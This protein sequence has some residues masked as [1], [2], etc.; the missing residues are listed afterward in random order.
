[1]IGHYDYAMGTLCFFKEGRD[2]SGETD[3]C[4]YEMPAR[5]YD[6]HSKSSKVLRMSRIFVEE[7]VANNVQ[8]V[9]HGLKTDL[10]QLKINKT[11]K[12]ALDQFLQTDHV[13]SDGTDDPE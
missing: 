5:M 6:Y 4:F 11:Y 3:P 13:E 2:T 8:V 12:D 10:E 7:D 1:M 9:E